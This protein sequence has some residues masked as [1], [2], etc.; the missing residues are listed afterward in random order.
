VK[1]VIFIATPHRG[2][3]QALGFL[4][5]VASWL[6]NLPGRLT[7]M[8]VDFVTLK[9]LLINPLSG[10]GMPTSIDNMNPTNPFIKNSS[11]IPIADGVT[12][13]SIIPVDSDAPLSEAG[14]GVVKYM[15]AHIDG[16]ESEKTVRSSHSVQGNPEAILEVKRILHEHAKGMMLP[17]EK[18]SVTL[19]K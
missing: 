1:R 4:G 15:S 10:S 5:S 13:H 18:S 6:V 2:S 12:A 11:S 16:V 14:D 9:G 7:K 8:G 17:N 19:N 3:Y